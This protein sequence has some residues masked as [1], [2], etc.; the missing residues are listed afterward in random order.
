MVTMTCGPA[1]IGKTALALGSATGSVTGTCTPA[2]APAAWLGRWLR[3]LTALGVALTAANQFDLAR[4]H[5]TYAREEMCRQASPHGEAT[6]LDALAALAHRD[7]NH[8][9]ARDYT[10]RAVQ[11]RTGRR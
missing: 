8:E 9:Q 7:G 10:T 3:A 1:G 6:V 11:L 5:L 2:W 4:E